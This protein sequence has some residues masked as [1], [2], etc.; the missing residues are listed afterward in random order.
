MD[1][2][3]LISIIIPVYNA[4]RYFAKCLSAIAL[5]SY[6]SFEVIVV[7]DGSSDDS[8]EIARKTGAHVMKLSSQSG[9]ATAR[10]Y[11]SKE[12]KG[13]ILLFV[14]SDIVIHRDTLSQVVHDFVTKPDIAALFGSYD[15]SPAEQ[16]FSSQYMNLR[17]HFVHQNSN[18][19]ATTF[20]AGCGAIRKTAFEAV[21][22]YDCKKY[23]RPCIE[24]IELGLRLRKN[25]YKIYLDKNI[26]VKH[27]KK[28]T[29]NSVI[30]TDIFH[31]AIPWTKLILT[32]Q[33]M[34]TDLNLQF[35]QKISTALLGL[36]IILVPLLFFIPKLT[37]VIIS[38]LTVIFILN[39][40]LFIFFLKRKG[41]LFTLSAFMMHLLYFFY[42]G[43]S[44]VSCW[45][46]Y[47]I[48]TIK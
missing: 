36:T 33:H 16:N 38:L 48:R 35:S 41:F 4:G 10:N 28:W 39:N 7:D 21:G 47:R 18:T 44:Y 45:L 3:P 42:S 43:A 9:P 32:S 40:K 22:G 12:A 14:D 15:D 46:L 31:R 5:S 20:W 19:E 37:I 25:G 34:I 29:L 13:D 6:S 30:R 27:L 1:K 2:Q 17:H 23:S 8:S 11:G 26:Q 24:D